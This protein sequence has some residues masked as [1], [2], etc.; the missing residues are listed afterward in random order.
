MARRKISD[1]V[2]PHWKPEAALWVYR[3][4]ADGKQ[5]KFES[6]KPGPA[7]ARECRRKFDIWRAGM[8]SRDPRLADAWKLHLED[9][10]TYFGAGSEAWSKSEM[11][12]RLYILP[13]LKAK[14]VSEITDQDWQNCIS[15]AT[16]HQKNLQQLAKKSLSNIRH[17]I[18][19]FAKFA[20]KNRWIQYK[21]EDLSIPRTAPTIGKQI[22]QPEVLKAFLRDDS[23]E[24][25]LHAWQL[26]V[27]TGLRPGEV[28]GLQGV[29]VTGDLI[30]I[31]RSINRHGIETSGKNNNAH[32]TIVQN[33]LVARV[34][35]AQSTQ[36]KAA[37]IISKWI[38]PGED[39]NALAP[40]TVSNHWQ[41]YRTNFPV[42]I[43]EYGLR[44]TFVSVVKT[45]LPESLLKQ[46]V[47][48]SESMD[49]IGV[50]GHR[51]D[52]EA[53]QAAQMIEEIFNQIVGS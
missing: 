32:R 37:G 18:M 17:A 16:P 5:L 22:L 28:Y 52:G 50:Y 15:K 40:S 19:T 24:W 7:G 43:T 10:E 6:S 25:F 9:L 11:V 53:E 29:D 49:T 30:N 51:I 21:P 1:P 27:V 39:G 13:R 42:R 31:R 20:K 2:I 35:A 41:K 46:V 34:L 36:L 4:Y 45:R 26:M 44:H 12:G 14:H 23:D 47:G 8:V 48:H 3:P 38:F 33:A